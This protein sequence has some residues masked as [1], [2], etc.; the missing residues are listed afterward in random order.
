MVARSLVSVSGCRRTAHTRPWS[1]VSFNRNL[2]FHLSATNSDRRSTSN[3]SSGQ[4][5]AVTKHECGPDLFSLDDPLTTFH[6][7]F[8]ELSRALPRTAGMGTIAEYDPQVP[9]WRVTGRSG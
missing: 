5:G 1:T 7:P 3:S 8:H 6:N 9:F 2:G 4:A